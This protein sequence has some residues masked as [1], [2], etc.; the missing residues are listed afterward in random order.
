[1]AGLYIVHRDEI[2]MNSAGIRTLYQLGAP[3]NGRIRIHQI[4]I[5]P[6]GSTGASIPIKFD[7]AYQ[8]E[9]GGLAVAASGMNFVKRDPIG[10]ETPQGVYRIRT[11]DGE[12]EPVT[13]NTGIENFTLHQQSNGSWAMSHPWGKV[14][15]LLG[16]EKI[17]LRLL[18]TGVAFALRY[19]IDSEE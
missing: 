19:Q 4:R 5:M 12:D 6:L 9:V 3:T 11:A 13:G 15:T 7:L 10:S 17:G 14:L 2:I 16:G 1:M 8:T 18:T